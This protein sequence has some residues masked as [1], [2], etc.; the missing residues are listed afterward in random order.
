MLV[1]HEIKI[2]CRIKV[3]KCNSKTASNAGELRVILHLRDTNPSMKNQY[4]ET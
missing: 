1:L 2:F 4:N 3:K